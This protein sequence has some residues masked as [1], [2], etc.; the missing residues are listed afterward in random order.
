ME[1]SIGGESLLHSG[2][3]FGQLVRMP[4]EDHIGS[5]MSRSGTCHLNDQKQDELH[6]SNV[7][8]VKKWSMITKRVGKVSRSKG[9]GFK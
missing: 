4:S 8:L 6:V 9:F 5:F 7:K 1:A 2:T 3:W